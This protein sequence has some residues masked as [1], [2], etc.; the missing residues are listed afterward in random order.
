MEKGASRVYPRVCGGTWSV[1]TGNAAEEGLSPRVRGNRRRHRARKQPPRSIP[2]CA[3]EPQSRCG[4]LPLHAVYPRVCGGT[5]CALTAP[6]KPTGLSPRVRG[7]LSM[8]ALIADAGRSIPACA[9]EPGRNVTGLLSARVY[10]RVCGGTFAG[11]CLVDAADGLSP[12]VRGNRPTM[13]RVP[14]TDR[15]IPACAGEPRPGMES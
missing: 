11:R 14:E 9:G 7:N 6:S 3:G 12:R 2:A 10:P 13:Y 8:V 5:P 4:R 1:E 15:S